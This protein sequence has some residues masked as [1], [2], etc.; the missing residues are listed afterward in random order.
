[1][2]MK[3]LNS[4]ASQIIHFILFIQFEISN[5]LL[6]DYFFTFSRNILSNY[7]RILQICANETMEAPSSSRLNV[8]SLIYTL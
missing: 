4:F 8:K 3:N 6:A 2:D 1:M 5:F 7:V